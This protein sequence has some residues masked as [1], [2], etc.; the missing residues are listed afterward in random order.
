MIGAW[1]ETLEKV[2]PT[3]VETTNVKPISKT[4]SIRN[5]EKLK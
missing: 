3:K 2:F 4:Y 5:I 1:T